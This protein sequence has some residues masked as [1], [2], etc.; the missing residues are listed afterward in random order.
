MEIYADF[1]IM[2]VESLLIL[3]LFDTFS[4]TN[5][6]KKVELSVISL[7]YS[8]FMLFLNKNTYFIHL[9]SFVPII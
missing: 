1:I 6:I 3:T 4:N 7:F 2:F 5:R 9:A 8:F